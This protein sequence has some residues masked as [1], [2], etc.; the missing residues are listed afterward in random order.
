MSGQRTH[1]CSACVESDTALV[2]SLSKHL[3]HCLVA[4]PSVIPGLEVPGAAGPGPR[5]VFG[6][7]SP[8]SPK[9]SGPGG[10]G[11]GPAATPYELDVACAE[12]WYSVRA[13]RDAVAEVREPWLTV[14]QVRCALRHVHV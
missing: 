13:H 3:F 14:V 6:R 11:G 4:A 2:L 9:P 8:T 10:S 1:R 7:L 5:G 12:A